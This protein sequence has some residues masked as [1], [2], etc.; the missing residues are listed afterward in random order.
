MM[1][2]FARRFFGC[3]SAL[4]LAASAQAAISSYITISSPPDVD[5]PSVP[6][7]NDGRYYTIDL[8][9]VVTEGDDW[10]TSSLVL[11]L[12]S[13]IQG[14][15]FQHPRGGNTPREP[16]E[17]IDFPALPYDTHVRGTGDD[18]GTLSVSS[19]PTRYSISWFAVPPNGGAGDFIVARLTIALSDA[20]LAAGVRLVTQ[21][22]GQPYA[23]LSG[24]HTTKKVTQLTPFN[25]TIYSSSDEAPPL[26]PCPGDFN[27]DGRR[28]AGDVPVFLEG[29]RVDDRGD[30]DGDGDTDVKDLAF[31]LAYFGLPCD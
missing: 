9:V 22:S 31:F 30:I 15:I 27:A 14:T 16:E 11:Q 18:V 10:T 6:N 5:D 17:F 2:F 13:A 24:G 20:E 29:W 4:A 1:R 12:D 21:D 23:A 3:V 19:T 8:H 7:F 28:D 25:F 26:E